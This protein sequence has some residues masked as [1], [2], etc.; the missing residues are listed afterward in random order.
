MTTEELQAQINT[1]L[2]QLESLQEELVKLTKKDNFKK[3]TNNLEK[4]SSDDK[5]LE[6]RVVPDSSWLIAILDEKDTHHVS[7]NS[8]FG[9][10]LPY[11]P[12]FYIPSL[13]YLET[14]SRLIR[15][16]KIPVKK[17][18]LK[19]GKFLQKISY[20]QSRLLEIPEIIQKYKTFSRVKISK[21]HPLDFYIV[22]EGIVLDAK[23]LTCDLG[24]Y[25]YVKKYYKNIYF[26]TDKVRDK[27][28]DLANLIKDIQISR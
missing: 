27:G 12:I 20:R 11:E 26:L 2:R 24:M 21:L 19:I 8:S 15:I 13:V 22:T 28:S 23:I 10:M 1:L 4:F 6:L 25:Y 3:G 9:A 14:I 16:N 7:A 17:C 18:E 5:K